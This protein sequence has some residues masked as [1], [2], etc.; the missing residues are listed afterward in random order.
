MKM[1][2]ISCGDIVSV[3]GIRRTVATCLALD[4][5]IFACD[6]E[7]E[8]L[9]DDHDSIPLARLSDII[10]RNVS[11]Y[12]RATL[13]QIESADV[14]ESH[15]VVLGAKYPYSSNKDGIAVQDLA[16]T[17]LTK[18]DMVRIPNKTKRTFTEFFVIDISPPA[19]A[20]VI[21]GRTRFE[22]VTYLPEL[23]VTSKHPSLRGTINIQRQALD[24]RLGI[25]LESLDQYEKGYRIFLRI[26]HI[27][28]DQTEWLESE[29]NLAAFA[30]DDLG[31]LYSCTEIRKDRSEW[32]SG[33]PQYR[34]LS[35]T[36]EPALDENA[37]K[38]IFV[39]NE[40]NWQI[41]ERKDFQSLDHIESILRHECTVVSIW[42]IQKSF[43]MIANGPWNFSI[44]LKNIMAPDGLPTIS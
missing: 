16:G 18:G 40:I 23:F 3:T 13:V 8:F 37:S 41:R 31:N 29:I 22:L 11:G 17:V 6:P 21:T 25:K 10:T 34:R 44:N 19:R 38:L 4:D 15:R 2:G 14:T 20:H 32:S 30:S 1:L 5:R 36:M 42:Q 35:V 9:N 7:F 12:N 26:D 28:D 39:V 27:F 43:Q 33:G 24:K